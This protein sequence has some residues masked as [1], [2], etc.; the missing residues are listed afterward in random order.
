MAGLEK[1]LYR[2]KEFFS[3]ITGVVAAHGTVSFDPI[4]L[5]QARVDTQLRINWKA[6]RRQ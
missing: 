4:A 6:R 5:S 2:V 1:A 3:R